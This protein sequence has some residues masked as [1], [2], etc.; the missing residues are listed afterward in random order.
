MKYFVAVAGNI[1]AGKTS[2]TAAL[3]QRWGWDALFEPVGE[4]PY[5]A[6]FYRDMQ[7]WGFH[8]QIF[9]LSRRLNDYR[10]LRERSRSVIQDRSVYEDAEI[11]AYNL[12]RQG[13]MSA[14]DWH[15]YFDLYQAVASLLPP[16]SLVVYV[17]ASAGTLLRRIRERGRDIERDIRPEYLEQLNELY[18]DWI[19]RFTV[20][21]AVTLDA[22][23]L[24]FAHN[25]SHMAQAA[26]MIRSALPAE[27]S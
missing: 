12:Y 26:E 27:N 6:D 13:H 11:F 20:C 9:F 22:D 2:L 5:L 1:G 10:G 25:E 7:R 23:V 8:S 17:R 4:N 16:P 14:R 18:E 15:A 19:K 21:R 3:A 24:D